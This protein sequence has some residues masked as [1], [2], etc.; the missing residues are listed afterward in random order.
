MLAKRLAVVVISLVLGSL[1]T[2]GVVE[3]LET[4]AA[5]YGTFYFVMTAIAV[6]AAIAI[7]LDKYLGTGFL[8]E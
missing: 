4:T 1:I 7:W 8:P 3:L 2:L 5:E 6:A